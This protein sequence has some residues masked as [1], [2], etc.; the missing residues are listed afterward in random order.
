MRHSNALATGSFV[1]EYEIKSVLGAGGFGITYLATDRRLDADVAIKEYF[2][3]TLAVRLADKRSVNPADAGKGIFDWGLEKFLKEAETLASLQNPHIVG[4]NRLIRAN[5]TAY[6]VLDFIDGPNFKEWLASLDHRPGQDELDFIV[7]RILNALEV[8]HARQLLHR[9]ISPR[10]IMLT[11]EGYPVLIDFGAARQIV[12][13]RSQTFAALLTPGYAPFEQYV[14][15][16]QGQGPWTDIY[17]LS[18]T[19]Y[20]A[21]AGKPPPEAPDRALA[22]TCVSAVSQSDGQYRKSFLEALDWGLK[23]MPKDRPQKIAEWKAR[24]M[25]TGGRPA[26]LSYSPGFRVFGKA[27]DWHRISQWLLRS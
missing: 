27:F 19:I 6:M 12:S 11:K 5:G 3:A 25:D 8:V 9:D 24:L 10:N 23:P 17:A 2:P 13:E 4:V 15:T 22:D 16:G 1:D 18:A 20:E 14:A 21:I 26:V 7:D